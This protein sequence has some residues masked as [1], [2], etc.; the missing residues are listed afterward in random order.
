MAQSPLDEDRA[1]LRKLKYAVRK[2][3]T[4]AILHFM[5]WLLNLANDAIEQREA[6]ERWQTTIAHSGRVFEVDGERWMI[7]WSEATDNGAS[8]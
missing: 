2:E 6:F 4:A 1:K 5:P 8:S 7:V 3:D